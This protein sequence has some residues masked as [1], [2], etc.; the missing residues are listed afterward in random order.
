M[1]GNVSNRALLLGVFTTAFCLLY[2]GADLLAGLVPYRLHPPYLHWPF[3]PQ[4]SSLYLSVDLMLLWLFFRLP[5]HR[6]TGLFCTLLSQLA[7]AGPLFVAFPFAPPPG[8]QNDTSFWFR[9]ADLINL[10]NN[11][12][13]S[14]HVA[15]AVTCALYARGALWWVW[16][17]G[18]AAS[19]L[20]THQHYLIDVLGGAALGGLT[21]GW[22]Q[23][24][25]QWAWCG[26]ELVRLTLRHARYGVIAAALLAL[27]IT[28][29]AKGRRA[30][31][32]FCYLQHLDD[33]LDGHLSSVEEPEVVARAQL[34]CWQQGWSD[35]AALSR[36]GR[37]LRAYGAPQDK[38]EAV[39][40][41]MIIDRARV[42]GGE[43]LTE[44]RLEKHIEN[45]FR[46]SLDLMLWAAESPLR[47]HQTPR[48]T[49]LLGWCS[50]YR[51]FEE[52]VA[53]GLFNFPREAADSVD[54]LTA[55]LVEQ[56]GKAQGNYEA[57]AKELEALAS[58]P[59]HALLRL[60]HRSVRKYLKS[61]RQ[62]ELERLSVMGFTHLRQVG[63]YRLGTVM[64][65][66]SQS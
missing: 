22:W 18:I 33:L 27:R 8:A 45:T 20:L 60:F 28:S 29:P 6:L 37:A 54:R 49:S 11:Y 61:A 57:A 63:E 17:T 53:L 38:I 65:N 32:G 55:W 51:D 36:A 31:L 35:E 46:L 34:E 14:L 39:I 40:E 41:E 44:A 42:K 24:P 9:L 1:S 15:F 58:Q 64:P 19:T 30:I 59:G 12:F 16:A 48:L 56:T 13:P 2:A 10:D 47:A 66:E 43:L 62:S 5:T 23:G 7:I 25:S 52:D 50:L 3:L 21:Y 26:R 4:L